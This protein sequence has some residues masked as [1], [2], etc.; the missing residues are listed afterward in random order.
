MK[1]DPSRCLLRTRPENPQHAR[2]DQ[3]RH[4]PA[5][6]LA[7]SNESRLNSKPDEPDPP[8]NHATNCL[9]TFDDGQGDLRYEVRPR[10]KY[11]RIVSSDRLLSLGLELIRRGET[12]NHLTELARARLVRDGLMIALLSLCP[13]RLRNLAE[14]H[15]GR[16]L[17][18]TGETWWDH[19]G[20][21]RDKKQTSRRTAGSRNP[22]LTYR[23]LAQTLAHPVPESRR[24]LLALHQVWTT[25]LYLRRPHHHRNNAPR[26]WRRG[27][28]SS[29]SGLRRV[30]RGPKLATEWGSP[31]D[32]FSTPTPAPP[33]STTTRGL[34]WVRC[35]DTNRS[36]I[37]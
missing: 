8:L 5:T 28:P 18:R 29:L 7:A 32:F 22:H 31:R 21:S 33:R 34:R 36:L 17:R 26:T 23:P 4:H 16:Q 14:L 3:T 2:K 9:K 19:T 13:I 11:H 1:P 12:S 24:C 6:P 15:V 27:Q 37:S 35:G 10:P 20:G 30:H 25:C